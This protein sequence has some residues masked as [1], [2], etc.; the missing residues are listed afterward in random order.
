METNSSSGLENFSLENR[1]NGF[2]L[3]LVISVGYNDVDRVSK[4]LSSGGGI[5]ILPAKNKHWWQF[6][7]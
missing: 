1:G 4:L 3:R 5:R 7:K 6:W 2:R